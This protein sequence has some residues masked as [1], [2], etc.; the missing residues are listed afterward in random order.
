MPLMVRDHVLMHRIAR[1]QPWCLLW[2]VLAAATVG[3]QKATPPAVDTHAPDI[4]L[5]Q[6]LMRQYR[7][8]TI[9][10]TARAPHAE[11]D[12]QSGDLTAYKAIVDLHREQLHVEANRIVG[13]AWAN[14]MTGTDGVT[15]SSTDGMKG[16][17]PTVTYDRR[18]GSQGRAHSDAGIE[19]KS[20]GVMLTADSFTIDLATKE[21]SF[22]RAV[23]II[24][25]EISSVKRFR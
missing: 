22:I 5:Q 17:S 18:E 8:S 24:D 23:T 15:F 6:I 16:S 20:E 19:I 14:W 3:C 11:I 12:R 7:G 9:E 25:S 21:S 4:Q 13:N 2:L 1:T 10:V